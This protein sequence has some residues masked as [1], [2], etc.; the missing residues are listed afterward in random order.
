MSAISYDGADDNENACNAGD[1]RVMCDPVDPPSSPTIPASSQGSQQETLRP[2]SANAVADRQKAKLRLSMSSMGIAKI[3]RDDESSPSPPRPLSVN[4]FSDPTF[5]S[6]SQSFSGR[7]LPESVDDVPSNPL[8][9]SLGVNRGHRQ[10]ASSQRQG[11]SRDSRAWEF[12]CD[13]DA[14]Q[15][16]N[17]QAE[18]E[19]RGSAQDAIRLIRE[20]SRRSALTSGPS[21]ANAQGSDAR[22]IL[23]RSKSGVHS[24]E[25]KPKRQ[26]LSRSL[27]S[28]GRLQRPRDSGIGM[29]VFV[30]DDCIKSATSPDKDS[31]VVNDGDSDKENVDP[32]ARTQSINRS[33]THS[34]RRFPSGA[35]QAGLSSRGAKY[36]GPAALQTRVNTGNSHSY[37]RA[38]L[39]Q[40]N[41]TG[42]EN[43]DP[44]TD[45]E[46]ASFMGAGAKGTSRARKVGAIDPQ[47]ARSEEDDMDCV[48][49]L[50]SLSQGA[51]R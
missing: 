9:S 27:T 51:W 22:P 33:E 50:L 46:I 20:S 40:Q 11:R 29:E 12:W 19:S 17:K 43:A 35:S 18:E 25:P 7:Q 14:G 26:S 16:L 2:R 45:P 39:P 23:K 30:D 36:R 15:A 31:H 8:A 24:S 6:I 21:G 49:G 4:L 41:A 1:A 38:R 48:Q 3:L 32:E 28:T 10:S 42:R 5:R 47:S 34:H 13:P 44:E 37:R